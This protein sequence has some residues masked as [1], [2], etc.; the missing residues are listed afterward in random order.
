MLA[1]RFL[2]A[3]LLISVSAATA[4]ADGAMGSEAAA[5]TGAGTAA[6]AVLFVTAAA[7]LLLV[8]LLR[9]AATDAWGRLQSALHR[10][11]V[12]AVLG[13]HGGDVLEDFL[14]ESAYGG[15]TR[16]DYALRLAGG[17][18]CVRSKRLSGQI[19]SERDDAQWTLR[20][21]G[22]EKQFLNPVVQNEGRADAL[23]RLVA[24]LPVANLVVFDGDVSFARSLGANVVPLAELDGA[25]KRIEFDDS[26]ITDWDAVWL[27]ISS[28]A[29][30]DSESRKDFAAQLSFG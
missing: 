11:R 19:L 9:P 22:I 23:R 25:L 7:A 27:K 24:D 14:L 26:S 18:V 6:P 21:A 3:V 29:L 5:A 2:T 30:T 16:I 13:R 17:I 15:L 1:A 12:R 4:L 28:A 10:R 8:V 20:C